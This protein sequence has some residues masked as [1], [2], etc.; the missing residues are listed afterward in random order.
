[1]RAVPLLA[2]LGLA[3]LSLLVLQVTAFDPT[4]WLIWGREIIH[5][6]LSMQAGPSWKPFPVVFTTIFALFGSTAAPLLWLVVARTGG[7]FAVVMMWRVARRMGGTAA[8][9]IA[10]IG[11]LLATH[12]LFNVMRGD[13]EGMLVAFA[14][15][16]FELHLAGR[17]R[18]AFVL[19]L[20]CGLIRPE[21]W[22]VLAVYGLWLLRRDRS[23]AL[24]VL[25]G[26]ALVIAAWFVP[27]YLATGN[28][29]RGAERARHPV[30]GSAGDTS[31]PFGLTFVYAT[32]A[33]V[34]PLYAGAA[35]SIVRARRERDLNRL[36]LAAAA[37]VILV[38]VA[39]LAQVG[40]TGNLRYL[41]LAAAFIGLLGA[42][43]L[44]PVVRALSP[45]WRAVAFVPAVAG[46]VV[47]CV[48]LG[49]E[50]DKLARNERALGAGLDRA[51]AQ[52]GGRRAVLRC[53][54][55]ATGDFERQNLAYKLDVPSRRV[56]VLARAPGISFERAGRP[57]DGEDLPVRFVSGVW[58]VAASC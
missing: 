51:I 38:T 22:I 26:G 31:F 20:V 48:I 28:L 52:A 53:G 19:G 3:V 11:M 58:T 2:C 47:A 46:V 18:A 34:W 42:A 14:L 43:G 36:G 57:V 25:G 30:A 15:V 10:A 23:Q 27:D 29:F 33:L 40:F 6:S 17:M 24:L 50:I 35:Y 44:P 21:V 56:G 41:T 49:H 39:A 16:A 37:G 13:S 1:M 54:H 4:A 45:L 9:W 55:I 7:F 5:G 32:I 8:G 12:F